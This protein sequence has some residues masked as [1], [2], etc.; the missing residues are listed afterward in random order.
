MKSNRSDKAV[1][2]VVGTTLLLSMA[3]ALFAILPIVVF[4]YPFSPA[5]SSVNIVATVESK[6]VILEHR[7]GESLDLI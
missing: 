2:E 5:P 4:S 7:G 3:V 6:N 1:S